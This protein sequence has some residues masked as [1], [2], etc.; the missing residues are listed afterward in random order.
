MPKKKGPSLEIPE[1]LASELERA[2]S[3]AA[4]ET[5]D[6]EVSPESEEDP[7]AKLEAELLEANE[8]H[9]RLAAEYDN[10]RRRTLKERQDLLN[11]GNE[12]LV[13]ELLATVDNLERALSHA[14]QQE[15]GVDR[16]N[17]LEGIELTHRSLM[18]A[19]EKSSVTIVGGVGEPFDPKVHE[20]IQQ[21]A[22]EEHPP[23]TVIEAYQKGYLM[24]DRLLRPALVVVSGPAKQDTE[25]S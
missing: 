10:Y 4:D 18:Q 14:R 23:G 2:A 17:L 21:V 15:E 12:N 20:A 6:G 8:R 19:L 5:P 25:S 3:D 11:Y 13:K 24:K 7:I 9:L 22:S 16:E 1:D